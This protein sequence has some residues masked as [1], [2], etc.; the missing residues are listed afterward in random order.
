[1]RHVPEEKP[2]TCQDASAVVLPKLL[3]TKKAAGESSI[4]V[5][6]ALVGLPADFPLASADLPNKAT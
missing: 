2:E 6:P 4:R 3:E 5:G 1:M